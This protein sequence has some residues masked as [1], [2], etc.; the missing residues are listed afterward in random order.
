LVPPVSADAQARAPVGAVELNIPAQPLA[1]ALIAF[2][3]ATG[4]QVFYDGALA[5]GRRSAPAK[6]VFTPMQGLQTLLRGTGYAPHATDDSD[7]I[8]IVMAPSQPAPSASVLLHDYES[9]LAVLQ[10]RVSDALCRSDE[11]R[12]SGEQIIVSFWLESSGVV[13]RAQ[14]LGSGGNA[15]RH[16]DIAASL[17]GLRIGEPPPADLPQ[18]I[19]MV[20]FP[21]ASG[22]PTGCRSGNRHRADNEHE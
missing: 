2:G 3:A 5:V 12:P 10:S 7:T 11:S 18:P 8:T 16:N 14:I 19:T 6:G 22:E 21:P 4:L 13:S 15:A 1:D 17:Q 20:I 9:Y